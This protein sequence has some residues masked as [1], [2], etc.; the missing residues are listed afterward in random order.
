MSCCIHTRLALNKRG[1]E[2]S[3]KVQYISITQKAAK[4]CFVKLY[5]K[6]L[7]VWQAVALQP[8]ELQRRTAHFWKPPFCCWDRMM[9]EVWSNSLIET[10]SKGCKQIYKNNETFPYAFLLQ[11][12]CLSHKVAKNI[13]RHIANVLWRTFSYLIS[14][15]CRYDE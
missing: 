2:V 10:D 12:T 5:K 13:C 15:I 7:Q 8:I 4:L 1:L 9:T 6:L 14:W 3:K 11:F